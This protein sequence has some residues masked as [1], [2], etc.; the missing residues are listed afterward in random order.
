MTAPFAGRRRNADLGRSV[1]CAEVSSSTCVR[2]GDK[3]CPLDAEEGNVV[4]ARQPSTRTRRERP[5]C[6]HAEDT[7]FA[8]S[9]D[10]CS[11]IATT[12][13]TARVVG[14]GAVWQISRSGKPAQA[15]GTG[16]G[17]CENGRSAARRPSPLPQGRGRGG[18]KKRKAVSTVVPARS[19]ELRSKCP[20]VVAVAEVERHRLVP[21]TLTHSAPKRVAAGVNGDLARRDARR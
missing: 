2:T 13:L 15:G 21:N 20:Y 5:P 17:V 9:K 4:S 16:T 1:S 10:P 3:G 7:S 11:S 6:R 18:S 14:G 8:R 19:R 12:T